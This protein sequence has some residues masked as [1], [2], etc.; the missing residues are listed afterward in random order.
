MILTHLVLF[1]L[2]R[3]QR[4]NAIVSH[5]GKYVCDTDNSSDILPVFHHEK[6]WGAETEINQV[7]VEMINEQTYRC[8]IGAST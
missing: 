2:S 8:I 5:G 6:R 7:L 1:F 4:A 3:K